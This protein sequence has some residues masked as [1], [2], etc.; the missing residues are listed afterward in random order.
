V[1]SHEYDRSKL[2]AY[3]AAG[4]HE[5]WLVLAPQ[6]QVE[7]WRRREGGQLAEAKTCGP[8]GSVASEAVPGFTLDLEALF[9]A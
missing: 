7:V 2:R 1:T 3:T 5:V 6:K 4:V 9:P 8:G